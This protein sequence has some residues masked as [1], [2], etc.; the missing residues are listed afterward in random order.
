MNFACHRRIIVTR[1][2]LTLGTLQTDECALHRGKEER[3]TDYWRVS[4]RWSLH[5][6]DLQFIRAPCS[7]LTQDEGRQVTQQAGN[8]NGP[9]GVGQSMNFDA[10][11]QITAQNRSATLNLESY[12][13]ARLQPCCVRLAPPSISTAPCLVLWRTR[14]SE[15]IP[16]RASISTRAADIVF[17][18]SA[19]SFRNSR[20]R[21]HLC[22]LP[23]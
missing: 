8:E 6:F 5:Q 3:P 23:P 12:T 13:P 11:L 19:S 7:F 17:S 14:V 22:W 18:S 21:H 20:L 10:V 4:L 15:Y 2:S 9:V 16:E 1:L